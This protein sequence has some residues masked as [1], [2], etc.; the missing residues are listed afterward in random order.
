MASGGGRGVG[1]GGGAEV[2]AHPATAATRISDSRPGGFRICRTPASQTLR[3]T[4]RPP[5]APRSSSA[6]D[7][8]ESA[9]PSPRTAHNPPPTGRGR[10]WRDNGAGLAGLRSTSAFERP[11]KQLGLARRRGG[12]LFGRRGDRKSAGRGKGGGERV[13]MVGGG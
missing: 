8:A 13:D 6:T 9:G 11:S 4:H 10:N 5:A 7:Q 1:G 12:R 3:Q 2:G